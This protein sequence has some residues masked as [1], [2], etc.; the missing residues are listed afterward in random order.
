MYGMT[1]EEYELMHTA[2][3]GK[4]AI[5]NNPETMVRHGS[6]I[7]LAVDHCHDTGD[8]RALLCSN[9]N[10][11]IGLLKDSTEVVQAALNYLE[12]HND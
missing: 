8:V 3:E 1:L 9:C 2:Q 12:K 10:R 5:C 7:R 6:T 4:C 11:G